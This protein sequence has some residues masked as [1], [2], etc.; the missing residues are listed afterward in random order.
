MEIIYEK[1]KYKLCTRERTQWSTDEKYEK[2]GDKKIIE[3]SYEDIDQLYVGKG[4]CCRCGCGGAYFYPKHE[5]DRFN[6]EPDRRADLMIPN[7]DDYIHE[8]LR[9]YFVPISNDSSQGQD[10]GSTAVLSQSGYIIEVDLKMG[11]DLKVA[12][13]YLYEKKFNN[14]K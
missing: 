10:W 12:T 13:L 8:I 5:A 6:A 9:D 11:N 14:E 2:L 7:S 4:D 1:V 3:F